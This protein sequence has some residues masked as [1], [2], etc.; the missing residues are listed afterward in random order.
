MSDVLFIKDETDLQYY[1]SLRPKNKYNKIKF[2]YICSKCGKEKEKQLIA[3][4]D[5]TFICSFCKSKQALLEKY[6]VTNNFQRKDIKDK[7]KQTCLNKYGTEYVTQAKEFKDKVKQTCLDKYGVTSSLSVKSIR[8]KIKETNLIKYGAENPFQSEEI[9]DKIKDTCLERYGTSH[10]SQSNIIKEKTKQNCLEKY[11]VESTN[12]LESV[13]QKKKETC[14]SNYGVEYALNSAEIQ[15]QIKQ[16]N[17]EKYGVESTNQLESVKQKKTNT[18]L[19]H[20]GSTSYLQSEEGKAHN[21]QVK[22]ERY[23]DEYYSGEK[24]YL[25][26][27]ILFRS[28]PELCFYIYHKDNNIPIIYEPTPYIEY[29][30]EG[31]EH[32]YKPDFLIENKLYE[33][34][35]D[36]FFKENKMVCPFDH[37]LDGLY[38][39]KHQCMI[40]NNVTILKYKDY[41]FYVNYINEKYGNDYLNQFKIKKEG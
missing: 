31:K 3:F 18:F 25:Y 41:I 35:G 21:K 29:E 7:I 24:K 13:K 28:K 39:A 30:Y 17:L 38:E 22:L 33:I 12:Q 9:K 23:G 26:E 36:Q 10:A 37:S 34:K 32:F 14:L 19:E 2:K 16:R 20:Y 5:N 8:D 4:K 40:R 27:D 6:G 1:K 15:E 11:G